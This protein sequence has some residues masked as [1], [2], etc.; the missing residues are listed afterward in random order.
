MSFQDEHHYLSATCADKQP[1]RSCRRAYRYGSRAGRNE[2]VIGNLMAKIRIRGGIVT[3][4]RSEAW[5]AD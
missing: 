3:C 1:N 5:N 4:Q 2:A